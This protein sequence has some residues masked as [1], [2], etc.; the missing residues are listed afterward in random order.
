MTYRPIGKESMMPFSE[1]YPYVTK[2]L[3]F[4]RLSP[5]RRLLWWLSLH[6]TLICYGVLIAFSVFLALHIADA[7]RAG[8][9]PVGW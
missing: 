6:D 5:W 3:V 7:A 1:S 4:K 8:R 2:P 9:F